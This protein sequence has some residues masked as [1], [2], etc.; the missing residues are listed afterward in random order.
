[1]NAQDLINE[2][3]RKFSI[4]TDRALAARLGMT[5]IA[6][7]NWKRRNAP[8]SVKQIAN[9]IDKASKIAVTRSQHSMIRPIV[10]FFPI[11]RTPSGSNG[12]YS[13]MPSGDGAGKHRNGLKAELEG[14]RGLYIF[15]DTRGKAL[16]AG[17][18]KKQNLWKEMNRAFNRDRNAQVMTL[19]RHP[20]NDV[21]FVAANKKVRQPTDINLKLHDLAAYFSVIEIT[22]A[23]VD[24]LEAL[25][26]RT[27]PNDLLNFKMEKFGKSAKKTSKKAKTK[28]AP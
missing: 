6:L 24:D 19:V 22:D 3:K 26:V 16:Y 1:M 12:K 21:A 11:E 13:V 20:T 15:Y 17:Q 28:K 8:L 18:T 7:G 2:L 14:A 25:L 9:A 4:S 23:M 5:E 27:F 10:E